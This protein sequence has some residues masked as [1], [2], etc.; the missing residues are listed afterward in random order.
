MVKE[1][2]KEHQKQETEA[3]KAAISLT[4]DADGAQVCIIGSLQLEGL[5]V[6]ALLY[7]HI[8]LL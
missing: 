5:S 6:G 3:G 8:S 7:K 1:T 4:P 2:K